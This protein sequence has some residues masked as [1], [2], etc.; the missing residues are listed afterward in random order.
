MAQNT[1]LFINYMPIIQ[2]VISW[3]LNGSHKHEAPET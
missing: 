2:F 1:I 3:R